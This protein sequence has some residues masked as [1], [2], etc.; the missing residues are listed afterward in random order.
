MSEGEGKNVGF[1][2]KYIIEEQ[3]LFI[4]N[5]VSAETLTTRRMM[6]L[7]T[8]SP[9]DPGPSDGNTNVDIKFSFWN[10]IHQL[11]SI[12]KRLKIGKAK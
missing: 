8:N 6:H 4:I 10:T 1:N 7:G 11:R 5:H 2:N 3:Q 9:P 12:S